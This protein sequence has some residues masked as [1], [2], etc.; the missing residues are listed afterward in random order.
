M[1]ARYDFGKGSI[2]PSRYLAPPSE[3]LIAPPGHW[4]HGA[5]E[6][7][8]GHALADGQLVC[9][10]GDHLVEID[11]GDWEEGEG[12]YTGFCEVCQRTVEIDY[13]PFSAI[14]DRAAA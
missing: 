12:F 5:F 2:E 9:P 1:P 3:E 13:E 14:W 6:F 4:H 10:Y 8:P 7:A 11:E